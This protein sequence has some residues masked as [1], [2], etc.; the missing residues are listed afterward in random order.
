MRKKVLLIMPDCIRYSPYQWVPTSLLFLATLLKSKGYS[1]LII[2]GRIE[3][4][5]HIFKIINQNIN[6]SL[7]IGLYVSCGVQ[8]TNTLQLVQYIKAKKAVPI[9]VG[10][11]M[12]S[13]AP[14]S[15]LSNIN[16][17]YAIAD[18]GEYAICSLCN[19]L[20]QDDRSGLD[21]I[22]NLWFKHHEK[23]IKSKS[24]SKRIDINNMPPLCYDDKS[25]IDIGRYINPDTRAINYNTSVGCIGRCGFCFWGE[26]YCYSHFSNDRA[27]SDLKYLVNKYKL[28]NITFD[29]PTFFVKRDLTMDLVERI[30]DEK[31]NVKWRANGRVDTLNKFSHE[32]IDLIRKSGCHLI[33]I[34]MES[35]SE[36]ILKLMNKNISIEDGLNTIGKF[37]GKDI[38]IRFHFILGVPTEELDDIRLTA[39]FIK[40]V[41]PIKSDFDYTINI[42]NPYPG[43]KLAA[44]AE[45]HGYTPPKVLEDYAEIEMLDFKQKV[46]DNDGLLPSIWDIDY[47]L[48][49]FSKEFN[50]K[51]RETFHSLIPK[52]D[53]IISVDGKEYTYWM[54]D[55]QTC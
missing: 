22:P 55:K 41:A 43:N 54:T 1:P 3:S 26:N 7:L 19:V 25:I 14:E 2:D 33:H 21:K 17:D 5:K 20:D 18:Q 11:P 52:L 32:D 53:S 12:P 9:V 27:I 39:D 42:F 38:H 23:I 50:R 28:R 49:W 46:P 35:G 6:E 40:K 8:L 16:I 13:A 47:E 36:R 29:D 24:P 44:L 31:L 51:H 45:K 30:I 48:P 34:G 4:R 10:G 15:L 37:V